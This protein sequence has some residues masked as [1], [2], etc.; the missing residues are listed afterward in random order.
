MKI[1]PQCLTKYEDDSLQRCP[2]DNKSL[3]E[4]KGDDPMIGQVILDRFLLTGFLGKGAMGAVYLGFQLSMRRQVA[5]KILLP[6]V[7]TSEQHV[8]RFIREATSAAQLRS[9]HTVVLYDFG[10]TP[11]GKLFIAMELLSG[12]ELAD[13]IDEDGA[14]PPSKALDLMAQACLSLKEA[15]DKGIVH[16]DLKPANIMLERKGENEDLVKVV[17]FGIAKVVDENAT[18]VTMDGTTCGTPAYMSPEQVMGKQLDART[19][20]YALGIV[21]FELLTGN[22]PFDDTSATALLIKQI[23][24]NIPSILDVYPNLDMPPELDAIVQ[25]CVAKDPNDRYNN[26]DELRRDCL[27][28]IAMLAG[29]TGSTAAYQP[30]VEEAFDETAAD[31]PIPNANPP[32]RAP[33]QAAP[34]PTSPAGVAAGGT[35]ALDPSSPSATV[36]GEAVAGQPAGQ[37]VDKTMALDTGGIPGEVG[38]STVAIDAAVKETHIGVQPAGKK[39]SMLLMVGGGVGALVVVLA[40][41]GIFALTKGKSSDQKKGTETAEK[42]TTLPADG[43]KVAAADDIK[44]TPAGN[45][46]KTEETVKSGQTDSSV[47][48]E[49]SNVASGQVASGGG[50][51]A[52]ADAAKKKAEADA[53]KKLADE[54]AAKKKEAEAAKKLADEEAA[55]KLADEKAAKKLADEEAAKKKADADAA[56]KLAD[57]EA[58]KKRAEAD[59]AKKKAEELAAKKKAE[60]EMK[61]KLAVKITSVQIVGPMDKGKATGA[62]K[63]IRSKLDKC[64]VKQFSKD[65]GTPKMALTIMVGANGKANSVKVSPSGAFAGCAKSTLK[66]LSY[67]AFE[68]KFTI[69][70]A[71]VGR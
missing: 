23:Q 8:Q 61:K 25:K 65:L 49:G 60:S 18:L 11:D 3:L 14:M 42:A 12:R 59:A 21:L 15:H 7:A 50:A 67:P 54:E 44:G 52:L 13:H 6:H 28:G 56:K 48:D 64:Y 22:R 63:S 38:T 37:G 20:I 17:D 62:L 70:K 30:Q 33:A 71:K 47:A 32:S 10:K 36:S 27:N 57:E 9:P 51:E 4:L 19:D 46:S 45:T 29:G 26:C 69:I 40:I 66:G 1:C 5:V 16:R 24:E 68:G 55:K 39:S 41:V 2:D 53:A 58:A 31:V 43:N 34:K 35:L